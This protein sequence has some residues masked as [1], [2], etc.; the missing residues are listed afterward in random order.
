MW[1]KPVT[2]YSKFGERSEQQIWEKQ[3]GGL[4]RSIFVS[5][6]SPS[7][8]FL[9]PFGYFGSNLWLVQRNSVFEWISLKFIINTSF[10]SPFPQKAFAFRRPRYPNLAN[11]ASNKFG[12]LWESEINFVF[13]EW[14][15]TLVLPT[16]KR[17]KVP[18]S[19]WTLRSRWFSINV[20]F[21][22]NTA[23]ASPCPTISIYDI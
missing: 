2:R 10:L 7:Y 20:I 8:C 16:R 6:E 4:F 12:R 15:C 14:S 21:H 11:E 1:L 23:R 3:S 5:Y 19:P 13:C 18:K 22:I 9:V 17:R